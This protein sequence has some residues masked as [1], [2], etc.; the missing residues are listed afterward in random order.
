MSSLASWSNS[1]NWTSAPRLASSYRW[2]FCVR[3]GKLAS[4]QVGRHQAASSEQVPELRRDERCR[5]QHDQADRKQASLQQI[6]VGC[7]PRARGVDHVS[8]RCNLERE[9]QHQPHDP[10]Q[11]VQRPDPADERCGNNQNQEISGRCCREDL[12]RDPRHQARRDRAETPEGV[13]RHL[14]ARTV[15]DRMRVKLGSPW[16][17]MSGDGFQIGSPDTA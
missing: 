11:C 6:V 7:D 1:R 3:F 14:T 12:Q 2:V 16:D 13:L 17:G 4:I 5:R 9:G 10:D 15:A 8:P